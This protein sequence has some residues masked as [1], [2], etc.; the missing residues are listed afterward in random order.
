V[1]QNQALQQTVQRLSGELQGMRSEFSELQMR[2]NRLEAAVP[3]PMAP[4]IAPNLPLPLT[5]FR[6]KQFRLLWRGTRDGFHAH[7]FHYRC[8]V[9]ADTVTVIAD[10]GGFIF[11]G[12]TPVAWDSNGESGCPGYRADPSGW[13]FLFTAKNPWGVEAQT[14]PLTNPKYAIYCYS[15]YG[16]VFGGSHDIYV[17][18]GSDA[19]ATSSTY[20][21]YSAKDTEPHP[22]TF[23]TDA[24]SFRVREI[25]VFQITG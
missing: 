20:L 2:L 14:F 1:G 24:R 6:G 12:F 22:H 23:F 11:G 25:E 16:P 17:A 8:D 3:P 5:E 19:N 4:L 9:Q 10:S 13:S 21:S 7:D 18:N 15:E